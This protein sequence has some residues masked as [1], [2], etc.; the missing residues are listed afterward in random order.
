MT[1]NYTDPNAWLM[2]TG[3]RSAKFEKEGDIVVGFIQHTE[4]RQQIDLD[5]SKPAFWDDGNPKM[6][7]V[8]TLETELR[9]DDDDDG[10]RNLYVR[11][12]LQKAVADAVRRAGARGLAPGGKLG[13]KWVSTA[14]P[15]KRGHNG[16]KQYTAK[17]EPPTQP[18]DGFPTDDDA[19]PF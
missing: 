10:L 8:V 7:L 12:Q 16:A 17:Y 15:K 6:Q 1:S 2:G 3:G 14:E 5:T 9:E 11:G 4:V 18:V 13:V 19:P